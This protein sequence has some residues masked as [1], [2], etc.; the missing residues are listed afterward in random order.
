MAHLK[1]TLAAQ[2][3]QATKQTAP[4]PEPLAVVEPGSH[5]PAALKILQ[6][7]QANR[8]SFDQA[9]AKLKELKNG[10]FD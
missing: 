9:M 1:A 7:L 10:S 4:Q 6:D 5:E 8:L 2:A 3:P